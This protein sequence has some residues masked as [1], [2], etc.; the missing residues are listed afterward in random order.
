[1]WVVSILQVLL[2]LRYGLFEVIYIGVC[3]SKSGGFSYYDCLAG[4]RWVGRFVMEVLE[5][6]SFFEECFG[7]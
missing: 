2:E 4:A 5:R 7:V 3:S 1:M 6:V